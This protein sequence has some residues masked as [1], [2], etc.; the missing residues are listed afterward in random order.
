MPATIRLTFC[1]RERSKTAVGEAEEGE[2]ALEEGL[3][4][5]LEETAL[6]V[7]SSRAG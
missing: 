5:R 3:E 1:L 4:E 7:M 6:V 2:E